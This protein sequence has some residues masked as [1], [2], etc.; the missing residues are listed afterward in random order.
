MKYSL[1][2]L[3]LVVT[4]A[5]VL[6]GYW[7]HCAFCFERANANSPLI[8]WSG[9]GDRRTGDPGDHGYQR[10]IEHAEERFAKQQEIAAAYRRAI[11]LPWER[12]WI[13]EALPPEDTP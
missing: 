13:D 5:A 10:R 2:S 7:R 1:R 4:L 3:M 6:V 12:I 8:I 9:G 11:W